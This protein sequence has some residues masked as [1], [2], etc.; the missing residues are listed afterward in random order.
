MKLVGYLI[1]LLSILNL[2][3]SFSDLAS[4]QKMKR[5]VSKEPVSEAHDGM[6][7]GLAPLIQY[8]WGVVILS[9]V[10]VLVGIYLAINGATIK[11]YIGL[12]LLF[13]GLSG[14][15]KS[16][17]PVCT[18]NMLILGGDRTAWFRIVAAIELGIGLY[19]II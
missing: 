10:A 18:I 17:S 5:N 9:L 15:M 1:V 8:H 13:L 19:L 16:F 4:L 12:V 7:S 14:F 6:D 2:W 3:I 11:Q